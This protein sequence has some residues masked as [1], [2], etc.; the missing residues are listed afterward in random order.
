MAST[1]TWSGP[2]STVKRNTEL[3]CDEADAGS[4]KHAYI[5]SSLEQSEK[6]DE[7]QGS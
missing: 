5:A 4:G 6:T 1:R 3:S 2:R 7:S